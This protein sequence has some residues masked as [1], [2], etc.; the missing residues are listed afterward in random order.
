MYNHF[1]FSSES[2]SEGH[3]DKVADQVSDAVL[4]ACLSQDAESRVAC[5]TL[6]TKGLVVVT[7]EI[8][9]QGWVNFQDVVRKT[10]R[11]I[12]YTNSQR[13]MDADA[14]AVLDMIGRQSTDIAMGIEKPDGT[15]GAGDQGLMF[16]YA[17]KETDAYMPTGIYYAHKILRRASELRRTDDNFLWLYP[18]AKCQI[19]IEYEGNNVIGIDSVVLSHQHASEWCGSTVE[20]AW[21]REQ[22]MSHIILPIL[23]ETGLLTKSTSYYVNP[24]GRFVIGGPMADAGVTGRKIIADTYGG[25]GRHGGGAFSGKDPTKVDRSAAYM[26]RYIAKNIVAADLASVCEVQLS[27]VIGMNAPVSIYIDTKGTGVMN[28]T[29]LQSIITKEF[30][31]TLESI[32]S[33]L[34]LRQPM[35]QALSVYGHF[36]RDDV[37]CTWEKTDKI[38]TLQAHC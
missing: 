37:T 33:K 6:V 11:E 21:I 2:V 17:C 9:T 5:E 31:L 34:Q 35:Y 7:G 8:T 24:T 10:I 38:A 36:G 30:D 15:I 19:T 28:D 25:V 13:G 12:G 18:D 1:L 14:I 29:R 23:D 16:G 32:I 20:Q 26:A 3:P 27:Y 22:V 4:D